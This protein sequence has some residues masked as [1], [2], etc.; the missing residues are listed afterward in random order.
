MAT[1]AAVLSDTAADRCTDSRRGLD[2]GQGRL[3]HVPDLHAGGRDRTAGRL[4]GRRHHAHG[5]GQERARTL[6]LGSGIG[7]S[8]VPAQIPAGRTRD[9]CCHA[10]LLPVGCRHL[11]HLQDSRARRHSGL[12][13]PPDSGAGRCSLADR[14]DLG[15]RPL[16]G[17]CAVERPVRQGCAGQCA[18]H[19]SQASGRSGADGSRALCHFG[20]GLLHAVCRTGACHRLPDRDGHEHYRR[21]RLHGRHVHGRRLRPWL[22]WWLQPHGHDGW[23]QHR[24]HRRPGRSLLRGGRTAGPGGHHGHESDLSAG[25]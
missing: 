19:R 9:I 10:G 18:E 7:R 24:P 6:L 20:P 11:F 25:S 8:A 22:R 15:R 17:P 21:C 13:G 1:A 16:D 2:A 5:Q 23:R 3:L 14:H 4:F 12:C